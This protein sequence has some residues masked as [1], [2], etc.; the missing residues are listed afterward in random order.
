M[1]LSAELADRIRQAATRLSLAK[2]PETTSG[3]LHGAAILAQIIPT[4]ML[5]VASKDG[6]SHNL[7]EFSRTEDMVTATRL[8]YTAV[9]TP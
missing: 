6:I 7:G 4:I 2:L 1:G 5:F 9:T 8:L 3:A